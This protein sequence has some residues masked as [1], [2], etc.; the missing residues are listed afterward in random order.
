VHRYLALG[1]PEYTLTQEQW[2]PQ[3]VH[4]IFT[5][6]E[7]PYN[8]ALITPDWLDFRVLAMHPREVRPGT[9]ITY[10]LR[11]LGVP[12]RWRAQISEW[13]PDRRFVD[14]QTSGPYILW[15]HTH[16]F[17]EC[18]GGVLLRDR[19]HYRLPFGPLGVLAHALIVRWQLDDIFDYRRQKTA[20][21]FAGG[22]D[23]HHPPE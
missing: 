14:L 18:S 5:F 7:N 2:L 15:H 3:P 23:Y 8:L 19:V 1:A 4:K 16:T 10:R 13:I 12:Y 6:F 22:R 21:L 9:A 20:T 17:E 11:W